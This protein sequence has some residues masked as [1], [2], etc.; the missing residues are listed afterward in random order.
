M[1][2]EIK[3][4][5]NGYIAYVTDAFPARPDGG[6]PFEPYVFENFEGLRMWLFQELESR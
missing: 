2:I 5:K 1:T 6:G 4:A 3:T